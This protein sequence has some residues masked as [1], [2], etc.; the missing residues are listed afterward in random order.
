MLKAKP[1]AWF[2]DLPALHPMSFCDL[3]GL[4]RAFYLLHVDTSF[5][6]TSLTLLLLLLLMIITEHS[7]QTKT[8]KKLKER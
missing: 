1:T 6:K 8:V 3:D 7:K 2:F 4:R 5:L